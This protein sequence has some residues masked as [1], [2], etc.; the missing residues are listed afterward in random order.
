[1]YFG[2]Y[3]IIVQDTFGFGTTPIFTSISLQTK[4]EINNKRS[5]VI[6]VLVKVIIVM[7]FV[8]IIVSI[9]KSMIS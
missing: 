6:C 5:V 8:Y 4:I 3:I 1:M 2:L 9:N 7:W